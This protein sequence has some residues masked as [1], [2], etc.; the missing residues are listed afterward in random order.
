MIGK[1]QGLILFIISC[2]MVSCAPS[3]TPTPLTPTPPQP[4]ETQPVY[5]LSPQPSPISLEGPID[6]YL[7]LPQDYTPDREWP[8]FIGLHG[9]GGSS[10]DC[11]AAWQS[12]ADTEGFVLMCPYL[13]DQNGKWEQDEMKVLL[14]DT[15]AQ[16]REECRLKPKAFVAG[17]SR[18]AHLTQRYA[19]AY[20]ESVGAVSLIIAVTYDPPELQAK[21]IPFLVISGDVDPIDA[22]EIT[23]DFTHALQQDGFSVEE[24][25]LPGVGHLVAEEMID[26]TLDFYRRTM[27]E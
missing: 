17:I 20:P 27:N 8:L 15:V 21:D 14:H 5:T 9:A 16:V 26:L 18:G 24:H 10:F 25:I 11:L 6:Y 23:Q 12:F 7:Y 13:A 3:T 19:W 1:K 2:F 4:T 22:V